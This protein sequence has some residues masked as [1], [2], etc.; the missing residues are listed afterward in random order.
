MFRL[1][2]VSIL[3][4]MLVSCKSVGDIP[5]KESKAPSGAQ[6]QAIRITRAFQYGGKLVMKEYN[7]PAGRYALSHSDTKGDF[8]QAPSELK[9]RD[10]P[11][12]YTVPGGVYWKRG[13][14][15]PTT[16]YIKA[17]VLGVT[18]LGGASS[19]PFGGATP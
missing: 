10:F 18:K 8:Y 14:A 11:L 6:A 9:V 3:G 1:F 7:L 16:I 2:I 15:K 13:E 12:Y 19:I 17:K 5:T 4:F